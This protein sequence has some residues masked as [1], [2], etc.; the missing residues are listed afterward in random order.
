M[1]WKYPSDRALV[2]QPTTIHGLSHGEEKAARRA[3]VGSSGG[4]D[5]GVSTHGTCVGD[6]GTS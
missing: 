1:A 6:V 4:L 2:P 5:H 3:G